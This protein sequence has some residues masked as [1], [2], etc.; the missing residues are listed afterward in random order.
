MLLLTILLEH[1]RFCG[2]YPLSEF[3]YHMKKYCQFILGAL[4]LISVNS[5]AAVVEGLYKSEVAISG[6]GK[7][8]RDGA[9][10]G[11]IQEVFAKV[12]GQSNIASIEGIKRVI[13]NASLY[14]QQYGYRKLKGQELVEHK[15]GGGSGNQVVWFRFD[16]RA[17]NKVLRE[18]NL[19][20]WGKTRPTTLVWLAI[21]EGRGRYILGSDTLED[22]RASLKREA[23]RRGLSILIPLL[24]LEDQTALP[25]ADLWGDFQETILQ[26]S[27]R[28]QAEAVLVGRMSLTRSDI[29]EGRWTL[30]EHGNSLNWSYQ[31]TMSNHVLAAG[32]SGAMEILA[33]QY[34]QITVTTAPADIVL[35]ALDVA[36][37][38]DYVRVTKYL[39]SL[40]QIKGIQ[41][42]Y[43]DS[44]S[45]GFNLQLR[46]GPEKLKQTIG[47]G[48]VLAAE[49]QAP[50]APQL[51]PF[52]GFPSPDSTQTQPETIDFPTRFGDKEFIFRLLP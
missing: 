14:V 24:D 37:L 51:S 30:Y 19:P 29:W 49:Q 3:R 28:Y 4:I 25:F 38:R 33:K 41:S 9:M 13:D 36:N 7:S 12:S 34:A 21:E 17:I 42:A 1:E 6:Q 2:Q 39:A 43:V 15:A 50:S 23:N 26:A 10:Q 47:L 18:N 16:E 40:E 8:E 20:V 32:V 5:H 27:K 44:S 46:G 45:V 48:S 35:S 31:G 11:A 22:V 52:G